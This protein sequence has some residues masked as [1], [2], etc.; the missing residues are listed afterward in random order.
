[1]IQNSFLSEETKVNYQKSYL[2]K[3]GRMG[4]T[5]DMAAEQSIGNTPVYCSYYRSDKTY[6]L[7]KYLNIK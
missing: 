3:V 2:D 5:Q 1:M 6:V 7:L 4:M